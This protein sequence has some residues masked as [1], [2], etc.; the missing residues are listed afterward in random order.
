MTE[1]HQRYG[2]PGVMIYWHIERRSTCIYSQLKSCSSSEVAAMIEGLLRHCTEVDVESNYVDT[3]GAS[4]VGFAFTELLGFRLLPRLKNIGAIRLYR[5]DDAAAYAELGSVLTRPIRWDLITQQ[6]DQMVKYST[7]LR[8]GTAESESILRRFTR[9]GPKH[10]TY[11]AL[12][13]LGR[14]VRTIFA[15]DYVASAELRREIH[16]GLQVVEHWNSGNTVIFY[17]KDG[18]LTGPDREHAEVSVLALHLLQSALVHINTL[19]LQAVLEVP[20]F[21][22]LIGEDER[23]ALTPLFWSNINPYGRC[24]LDMSTRLDLSSAGPAVPRPESVL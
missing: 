13:E 10:P 7:A 21:H 17:G 12:E 2:G 24:R 22:D 4:V 20:Q 1:W 3:H 8:L 15:C 11:Q 19:L 6:Y 16:G 14:A 5:P 9:G 23:R 18:D